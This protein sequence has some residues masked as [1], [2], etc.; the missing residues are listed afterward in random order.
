MPTFR[1]RYAAGYTGRTSSGEMFYGA[2]PQYE[3]FE[4]ENR[5]EAYIAAYHHFTAQGQDVTVLALG[6]GEGTPLGFSDDEIEAIHRAGIP[7]TRGTPKQG[8]QIEEIVQQDE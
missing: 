2:S 5:S 7:L 6:S 1:V 3:T 8:I 4:M